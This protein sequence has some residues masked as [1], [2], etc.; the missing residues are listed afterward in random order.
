M[1]WDIIKHHVIL[2]A[3]DGLAGKKPACSRY[4]TAKSVHIKR[5]IL[6]ALIAI[7]LAGIAGSADDD[8]SASPLAPALPPSAIT[9]DIGVTVQNGYVTRGLVLENKGPAFQPYGDL[10]YKVYDGSGFINSFSLQAGVWN[11]IN[12]A[13]PIAPPHADDRTWTEI[14]WQIGFITKFDTRFSLSSA[15]RQ[16]ASPSDAYPLG[17]S[18]NNILSFDDSGLLDRNFSI[19]PHL[20]VLYE[21]P[22]AGHCGLHGH[23]WYFE[24]GIAPTYTSFTGSKAPV[25]LSLPVTLGLGSGFYDGKTFGYLSVGPQISVLLAFIPQQYGAWRF[26]AGYR[27]YCLGDTTT[28]FAPGQES[29]QQIVNVSI[30]LKF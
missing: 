6:A 12:L 20:T 5:T 1:I 7:P 25:T 15:L 3:T 27:Y 13:A 4:V 28:A 21:L 23:S 11:D 17:R 14:Y 18:I 22:A 9:G 10:F 8:K 19:Q 29:H 30:G 2:L 26:S 24:P 16:Y